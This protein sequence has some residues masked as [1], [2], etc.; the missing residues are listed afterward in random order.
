[1]DL[2]SLDKAITEVT[3]ESPTILVVVA[4]QAALEQAVIVLLTVAW[5]YKTLY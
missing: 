1:V 3:R 5:V 2:V 4:V